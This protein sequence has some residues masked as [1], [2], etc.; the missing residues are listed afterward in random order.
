MPTCAPMTSSSTSAATTAR[1]LSRYPARRYR[2][3]GIDPTAKKFREYYP[4]H[5]E[6][7]PDFFSA[8][9]FKRRFGADKAR[10]V[11]SFS[12]FYDLEDPLQ[13]MREVHEVL[14]DDGLWV[15]EQ[16]YMPTM[17]AKNSYDTVCHEHLEYYALRQIKW[18]T[19]RAGFVIVDVTFNDVN[20]GSFSVTVRKVSG[21]ARQAAAV[22]R[23]L[24]EEAALGLATEKPFLE[25]AR[26]VVETKRALLAFIGDVKSRGDWLYALGASTKGNVLLQYCGLTPADIPFVGEV[27]REKCGRF[28]PGCN[29]PIVAEDDLLA[30]KPK[31]LLVLP[32]HFKD[33]FVASSKFK[34]KSL[35][36]P[37]PTVAVVDVP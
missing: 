9:L 5:V 8:A 17:L 4:D 24:R 12:M 32:W 22:D 11:T 19:D 34:G 7:I 31:Y 28:T 30:M 35:V 21:G 23:I 10:V 36:F 16:S 27:N 29:I 6:L 13:F 18:M 3:V 14:A 15:F 2:L 33:H 1:R 37:L 26:R 25:F 20:G